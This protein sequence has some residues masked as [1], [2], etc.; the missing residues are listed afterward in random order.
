[1]VLPQ[2]LLKTM[3]EIKEENAIVRSRLDMQDQLFEDQA[4]TNSHIIG[5][6]QQI[7]CHLPPIT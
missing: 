5:M 7:M 4:K 2:T 1:M 6:L 3:D